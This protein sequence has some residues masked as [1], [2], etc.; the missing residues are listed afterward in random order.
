M[1]SS[2]ANSLG[3]STTIS[4]FTFAKPQED[5]DENG[6]ILGPAFRTDFEMSVLVAELD[7][8]MTVK[9]GGRGDYEKDR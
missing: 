9:R 2:N 6:R 8:A 1:V 5:V 7:M 3:K 4:F